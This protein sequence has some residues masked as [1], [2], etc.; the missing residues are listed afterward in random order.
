MWTA[1]S[2]AVSDVFTPAG[3][4]ALF[5]SLGGTV[6]LLAVLWVGA[7]ALLTLVHASP[8][9]GLNIVIDVLGSLAALFV[10]W[11]LFPSLSIFVLG[12]F[13]DPFVTAVEHIRYPQLPPAR[14]IGVSELMRSSLQLAIVAVVLNLVLLP[15]YFVPV[16]NVAAYYAIN[17]YIVGRTYFEAIALRR[18][19]LRD[20]R[21]IW[22]GNRAY[23]S[24]AGA[25]IA[26]LL[27]LPFLDLIAPLIGAAVMLHLF[28]NARNLSAAKLVA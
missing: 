24:M 27:T 2:L 5:L 15:V 1:F 3:R 9:H 12:I 8:F 11:L 26:F 6:A 10:A 25:I 17:G 23:F 16:V 20:V 28:E 14:R 13:L 4:R 7:A 21:A 18:I 19:G 22:R